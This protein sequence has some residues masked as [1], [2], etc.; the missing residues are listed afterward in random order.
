MR[1]LLIRPGA[2]GDFLVSLPALEFLKTGYTE[3]WCAGQ[4][5]PLAQFCDRARSIS[6]TALDRVGILPADD[7]IEQFRQF[8]EIHS[9]YGA[10]RPDFREAV[11]ALPFFFYEALPPPRG[12][13][14]TEF[15]CGQVG[16]PV[17]LPKL[18]V[19]A[20]VTAVRENF[21]V[22]HPFASNPA[23]RWP[24]T[25]FRELAAHLDNVSWCAGPEESLD[26]A[27]RISGLFEL[28]KW[29]A[30]ARVFLGNDSG[31]THLAA[32]VETPVVAIFGPTDP[33]VWAPRGPHV[34]VLRGQPIDSISTQTVLEAA[35]SLL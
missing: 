29:L 5:V 4:N 2:I 12:P 26:G 34:R 9:W 8:D 23:K 28:A 25:C 22:I 17:T 21:C 33:A 18:R 13:H 24:L 30:S 35:R 15:Y 27:V 11:A 32:A 10:Q 7:V 6:S 14:A 3:I 20:P 16:A 1:R 19:R 31:I